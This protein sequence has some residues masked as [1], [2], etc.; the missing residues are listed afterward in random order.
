M[1]AR[2]IKPGFFKNEDLAECSFPARILF[3][4]LWCLADREGRFEW[5]PKR[6]K[7]E[8]LPYDNCDVSNLLKELWDR[9]FLIKYTVAGQDYGL[10]P[11]FLI[12]Q[13][14]HPNEKASFV[15]PP[16]DQAP[17][18]NDGYTGPSWV[19]IRKLAIEKY[20][21]KCFGCGSK[22]NIQVH[23]VIPRSKGGSV[24]DLGNLQILCAKCHQKKGGKIKSHEKKLNFMKFPEKKQT[25]R[26]SSLNPSS[27]NHVED[28]VE[29][30]LASLLFDLI[31]E[32]DPKARS[33]DLKKWVSPI[34]LL[35]TRDKRTPD[36]IESVIKWCQQDDF[37]KGNILSANKL[38][39]KFQQLKLQMNR[40]TKIPGGLKGVPP[41]WGDRGG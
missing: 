1:R 2:N 9:E 13:N 35:I 20:G 6:I 5:K 23:H 12:H 14:P 33:P 31:K 39:E 19:T 7:A 32:N 41:D 11:S 26:A 27:L 24:W 38:R 10:I 37:W 29:F 16:D 34:R 30:R 4:G 18:A 15:P 36:E 21:G 3:S 28:S 25:D 40:K 22:K 8:I 17:S